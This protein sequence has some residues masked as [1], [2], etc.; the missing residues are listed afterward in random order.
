MQGSSAACR[1]TTRWPALQAL[2]KRYPEM[3]LDR[4]GIYGWSFGGYMAALAVLR[5]P[6]VFKAAVAGA[7]VVDWLDYDTHYTERY[8]GLPDAGRR[9]YEESSLLTYA[10]DL[11]PAAAAHPRHRRRQ[12]LLPPHPQAGRRALPRRQGLRPDSGDPR[13]CCSSPSARTGGRRAVLP[14]TEPHRAPARAGS[15][16][17]RGPRSSGPRRRC[18]RRDA[19]S[20]A[21]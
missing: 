16:T 18:T 12:R 13:Q 10:A 17:P 11:T 4:V 19:Q 9:A 15:R 3:D 1:S 7:P 2:G 8:L 14:R 21:R 20:R 5:R 6:D